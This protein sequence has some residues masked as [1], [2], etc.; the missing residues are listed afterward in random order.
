MKREDYWMK[1]M[2]MRMILKIFKVQVD[3]SV[4]AITISK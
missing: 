3:Q 2:K 4:K 1:A